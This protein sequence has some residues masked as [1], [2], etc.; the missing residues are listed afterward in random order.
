MPG[1]RAPSGIHPNRPD[2]VEP[3]E[4]HQP[5]MELSQP[6]VPEGKLEDELAELLG[7]PEKGDTHRMFLLQVALGEDTQVDNMQ[8]LVKLSQGA[9][10]TPADD[11]TIVGVI[12][13]DDDDILE[14]QPADMLH[15]E[16]MVA[17]TGPEARAMK[18]CGID[19]LNMENLC[20]EV[21][22]ACARNRVRANGSASRPQA[23]ARRRK[24]T[25]ST[26]D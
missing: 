7:S 8:E 5:K 6:V 13:D 4:A 20:S 22:A 12:D 3:A 15:L 11:E 2:C 1:Q 17:I 18:G 9:L 14:P 10:P 23:C 24:T 26:R 16:K 21:A 25:D 19:E